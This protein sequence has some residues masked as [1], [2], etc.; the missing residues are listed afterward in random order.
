MALTLAV[1]EHDCPLLKTTTE[2]LSLKI[3]A[4]RNGFRC[5]VC[6]VTSAGLV[7]HC[8]SCCWDAHQTCISLLSDAHEA[9]VTIG[10]TGGSSESGNESLDRDDHSECNLTEDLQRIG[11]VYQPLG[12]PRVAGVASGGLTGRLTA[13]EQ[14]G[15][16]NA[17]GAIC[18]TRHRLEHLEKHV[19]G[20]VAYRGSLVQRVKV[21]EEAA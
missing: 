6:D 15:G 12:R 14:R 8:S 9:C 10:A 21:L 20:A 4:Y 5:D 13:L 1:R 19:L 18:S 2:Q 17:D 7:Y 3:P 11:L 16:Q